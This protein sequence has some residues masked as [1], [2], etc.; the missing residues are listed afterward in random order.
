MRLL[1]A[2]RSRPKVEEIREILGD[3][4]GLRLLTPDDLELYATDEEEEI[5]VFET[6]E[7][8]ALAKARWFQDRSGL[9]VLADDSGIVVDALDG[10]P[11]VRSKRFA[12]EG[13]VAEV[14]DR[15]RANNLHLLERLEGVPPARRR[16]RFVC[17]ATLLDPDGNATHAR[18]EVE[19]RILLEPAGDG[20]FGYDP[21][22]RE[23][24]TGLV[25]GQ[26]PRARKAELSHR[27]RAFRQMRAHLAGVIEG[28][29]AEGEG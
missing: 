25:F 29:A 5:E 3:L 6:F 12:P 2:T 21:L 13:R 27:G 7:G 1:L 15:D 23:A 28:W 20:G 16:A 24:S 17:V 8:N 14:G 11:G 22:F 19:G 4:E 10:A 18:G 26:M 9:P